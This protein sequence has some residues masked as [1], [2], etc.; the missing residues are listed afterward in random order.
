M[1]L[2]F[3]LLYYVFA[4]ISGIEGKPGWKKSLACAGILLNGVCTGDSMNTVDLSGTRIPPRRVGGLVSPLEDED[5]DHPKFSR[6]SKL[7]AAQEKATRSA[8]RHRIGGMVEAGEISKRD[9]SNKDRLDQR[10]LVQKRMILAVDRLTDKDWKAAEDYTGI[11]V[12]G[13]K[14]LQ[15]QVK[16]FLLDFSGR[17][18]FYDKDLRPKLTQKLDNMIAKRRESRLIKRID[19]ADVIVGLFFFVMLPMIVYS[20]IPASD[21]KIDKMYDHPD[22]DPELRPGETE[23]DRKERLKRVKKDKQKWYTDEQINV[24][25]ASTSW[26]HAGGDHHGNFI[27]HHDVPHHFD[28]PHIHV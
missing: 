25:A 12:V 24:A 18:D 8:F 11:P 20:W 5:F 2:H 23:A 15:G 26:N 6:F 7:R 21:E 4:L 28:V 9:V 19:G 22:Q 17:V 1:K 3:S 27:P 13:N 10:K 14:V 16:T